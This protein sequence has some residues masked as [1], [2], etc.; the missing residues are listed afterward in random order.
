MYKNTFY[1]DSGGTDRSGRRKERY[2]TA[3]D[4]ERA[5]DHGWRV[6]RVRLGVYHC[7]NCGLYHLT[8]NLDR[9]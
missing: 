1:N 5:P 2:R 8:S 4:A 7:P 3:R 6:R 9:Y